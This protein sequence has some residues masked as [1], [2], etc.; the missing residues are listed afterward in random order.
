MMHRAVT[1]SAPVLSCCCCCCCCCWQI[2]LPSW[3]TAVSPL[4]RWK[5]VKRR[6]AFCYSKSWS[7]KII[8][9]SL[10]VRWSDEVQ[11]ESR[12]CHGYGDPHGYGDRNS[13]PTAALVK[14]SR[15]DRGIE[16]ACQRT[17][18]PDVNDDDVFCYGTPASSP[19][20]LPTAS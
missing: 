17:D 2:I 20:F 7:V 19:S 14:A 8:S 15:R 3:S 18:Q 13:V 9:S 12:V 11:G 1:S 10:W 4:P 5:R 16:I 6:A